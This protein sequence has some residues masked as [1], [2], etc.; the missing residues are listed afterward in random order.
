MLTRKEYTPKGYIRFA[1][2]DGDM[3]YYTKEYPKDM[4]D[5]YKFPVYGDIMSGKEF[6]EH[7]DS[8]S[9]IDYDGSISKIIID[10]FVSNLGLHHKGIS[11]GG[12]LVDGPTWI[13]ICDNF[14]N[15]EVIWCN[16]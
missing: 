5:I 13:D 16:K 2:I 4:I 10:G 7:V 3:R 12:F 8:G 6:Y 11:Q 1:Y 15:V 9:F 14:N